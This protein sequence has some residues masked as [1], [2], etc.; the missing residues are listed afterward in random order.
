MTAQDGQ[1]WSWHHKQPDLGYQASSRPVPVFG[2]TIAQSMMQESRHTVKRR[3]ISRLSIIAARELCGD[4]EKLR[5]CQAPYIRVYETR[6]NPLGRDKKEIKR[7]Q[8]E[9]ILNV[10][11]LRC[12]TPPGPAILA[13]INCQ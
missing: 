10:P 11:E 3:A 12:Q 8:D 5:L 4:H 1:P 7:R 2:R 13:Y 9:R 6:K